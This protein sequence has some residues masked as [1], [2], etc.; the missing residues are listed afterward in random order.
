MDIS[1]FANEIIEKSI[2]DK[3]LI[4]VKNFPHDMHAWFIE[5]AERAKE[6]FDKFTKNIRID[7]LDYLTPYE[8]DRCLISISV[9]NR[10]L[11]QIL[12]VCE[13]AESE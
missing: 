4:R 6:E 7:E 9:V 8:K 10:T 1:D 13:Q 11:E 12:T 2:D 3:M 5:K